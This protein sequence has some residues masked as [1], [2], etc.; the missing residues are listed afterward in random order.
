M[1]NPNIKSDFP[2]LNQ[3]ING[4]ELVYLDNAATTQ[5]PKIVIDTIQ[6]YYNETNSNIHRGVH[7]LSQRA[8]Q[9]YESSRKKVSKFINSESED[10][11]I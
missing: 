7:T 4:E 2:A 6:K 8:T 1:I 9:L 5:K 11:I 3:K 10:Q